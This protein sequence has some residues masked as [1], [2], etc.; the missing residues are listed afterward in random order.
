MATDL[1][2]ATT[3]LLLLSA[4]TR[5]LS[6]QSAGTGVI[7]VV[8]EAPRSVLHEA[9]VT[10][11]AL[12]VRLGTDC[13]GRAT[14]SNVKDGIYEVSVRRLGY[15]AAKRTLRAG[16]TDSVEMLFLLEPAAHPLPR[17]SVV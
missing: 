7:V 2:S 8:D 11:P 12:D 9:E 4:L 14:F 15:A 1:K 5:G 17:V 3:V 10:I 6:A 16:T 13:M